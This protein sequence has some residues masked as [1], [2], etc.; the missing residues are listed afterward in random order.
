MDY[1]DD[2]LSI[3]LTNN[4]IK[5]TNWLLYQTPHILCVIL[6]IIFKS[7]FL[8]ISKKEV[9]EKNRVEQEA[10]NIKN[11]ERKKNHIYLFHLE[12]IYF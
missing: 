11:E 2:F 5:Q 12:L 7:C 1:A 8:N 3:G 10:I 4:W 6:I 9:K